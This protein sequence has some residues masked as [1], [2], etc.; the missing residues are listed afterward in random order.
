MNVDE[1]IT[2][3]RS[4]LMSIFKEVISVS[5]HLGGG[6][7]AALVNP[8]LLQSLFLRL[9]GAQEQK[10]K[11]ICWILASDN[12]DYRYNRYYRGWKLSQCSDYDSKNAVYLDL[13]TKIKVKDSTYRILADEK[14]AR[15]L[16]KGVFNEIMEAVD[17]T[18][19]HKLNCRKF[20]DFKQV[21]S[22]VNPNNLKCD[23]G[24]LLN[25]SDGKISSGTEFYGIYELL[26]RHR[27]RCAHNTTSYQ[28]NYP[29]LSDLRDLTK[30]LYSNLFMFCAVLIVIDEQM[31]RL[32]EKY[33]QIRSVDW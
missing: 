6:M 20:D 7:E 26:F 2:C 21:F 17:S 28:M 3:V 32:F 14:A 10:M 30:Q 27:N 15:A 24:G 16:I 5:N 29:H 23:N 13:V 1:H 22:S 4:R 8:Y 18:N 12:L 9:T 31:I 25:K 19:V 11:C 33:M